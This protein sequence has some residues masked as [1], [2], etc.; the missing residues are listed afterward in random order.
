MGASHGHTLHYH[1]HSAAHRLPAYLK[2][3]IVLAFVIGVVLV[4]AGQWWAFGIHAVVLGVA[5]A[6][7][8][9]P[10]L[11]LARRALIEVPFLVFA[12]I[13]PFVSTGPRTE[14][15]G[16]SVSQA[17][18]DAGITLLLK[19]SLA[20]VAA[21]LLAATTEARDIVALSLIHISEPT[22]PY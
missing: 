11:F 18:L 15:L 19:G 8:R 12:V 13:M 10:P 5:V 21:L 20:V 6:L 1:G 22:R 3:L 4:P 9:V 17:G 7:S 2:I 14:V 16:I